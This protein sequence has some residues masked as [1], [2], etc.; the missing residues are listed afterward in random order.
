MSPPSRLLSKLKVAA[1]RHMAKKKSFRSAP[2]IVSGRDSDLC[3]RLIRLASA[4]CFSLRDACVSA[5]RKKPRQEIHRCDGHSDAKEHAGKHTLG[6]AFTEGK[7]ETRHYNGN[8]G[9]AAS[10]GAGESL[11]QYANGVLPR[12]SSCLAE[13]G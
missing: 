10:D 9:E 6:A 1:P 5:A 2:R 8:E 13:S 3:T 7:G 12:R 4:M 11:L